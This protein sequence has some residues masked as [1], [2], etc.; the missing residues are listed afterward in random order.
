MKNKKP[1]HWEYELGK[2]IALKKGETG[3]YMKGLGSFR[4]D[5]LK[6]VVKTD[7]IINMISMFNVDDHTLV[8][9]WLSD[10]KADARK[11]YINANDFDI[12]GI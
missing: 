11:E 1:V 8:D 6:H 9:N 7:G 3:K 4:S 10:E 5:V 12:T 2:G